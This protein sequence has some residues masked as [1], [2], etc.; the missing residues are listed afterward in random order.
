MQGVFTPETMIFSYGS[1]MKANETE[2]QSRA[3]NLLKAELKRRGVSYRDLA[4]KLEALGVQESERN[5]ANK[6]SR[7]GFTAVFLLQVM[8][9]IGAK[10]LPIR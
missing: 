4:E 9:A 6:I 2:W 10:E 5:I 8:E 7:G 1:D 3:K